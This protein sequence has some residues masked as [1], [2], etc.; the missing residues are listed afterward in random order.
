MHELLR[1]IH[2]NFFEEN[3]N[4]NIDYFF[5]QNQI[6]KQNDSMAYYMIMNNHYMKV[7]NQ[8]NFLL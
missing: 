7:Q 8:E 5:R 1:D 2:P 4:T 6:L 3:M